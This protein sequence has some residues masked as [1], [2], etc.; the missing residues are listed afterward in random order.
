MKE[1]LQAIKTAL[2]P[3]DRRPIYEWASENVENPKA[4]THF[5][6]F[7]VDLSRH[8]IGPFQAL[9]DDRIRRVC[10]R[11][12]T[13]TGGSVISDIWAV[14]LAVNSP[15][16]SMWV[17]QSQDMMRDHAESRLV[18]L[19]RDHCKAAAALLPDDVRKLKKQGVMLKNGM[20]IYFQGPSLKRLQSK[21]ICYMVGDEVWEWEPGR[22]G[23]AVARLGAFDKLLRSKALLVS[24]GGNAGT[25]WETWDSSSSMC[26]WMAKC[27]SCGKYQV[28]VFGK[29]RDDGSRYGLVWNKNA[30]TKNAEG[31]YNYGEIVASS[32][33]E[34]QFCGHGHVDQAKTQAGWNL[35]GVYEAQ[36]KSPVPSVAGFHWHGVMVKN[37]PEIIIAFLQAQEALKRGSD[38]QLQD[39]VKKIEAR[40]WNQDEL[41][42]SEK[43]Q[44]ADYN[45][46]WPDE[47]FRFMTID[48]MDNYMFFVIRAWALSG[49]SRR[50][51]FGKISTWDDI[52]ALQ[53]QHKVKDWNVFLDARDGEI[54]SVVL[55]KCVENKWFGIM[56]SGADSFT[57]EVVVKGRRIR[58]KCSFI[59]NKKDIFRGTA[60]AGKS[61]A[62]YFLWSNSTFKPVMKN[63]RD[64]KGA[65]WKLGRGQGLNASDEEYDIQMHSEYLMTESDKRGF[66]RKVWTKVKGRENH[67]WDCEVMQLVPAA[68]QRCLVVRPADAPNSPEPPGSETPEQSPHAQSDVNEMS[69]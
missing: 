17:M 12:P 60:K 61:F 44:L 24:Q 63:L 1:A 32:R 4:W 29:K 62:R 37:W 26:E 38:S 35:N 64:G 68:M 58:V 53:A 46:D 59:V 13:Q 8:F 18:P 14:Y 42:Q 43:I 69:A 34:C 5:G 33:Y 52:K 2:N 10:I 9:L 28:P 54:T 20:P 36:N 41:H 50:I 25:E 21:G 40:H 57:R 67:A 66:E 15:A 30:H 48:V 16:P 6:M 49:E 31:K 45:P 23:Q 56:G 55:A 7:S 22:I 11:K 39:F 3:P 19:F 51:A 27:E 47:K 65:P